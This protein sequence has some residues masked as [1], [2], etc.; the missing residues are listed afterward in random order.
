MQTNKQTG[1]HSGF[2]NPERVTCMYLHSSSAV[3]Q[4]PPVT[5]TQIHTP[6]AGNNILFQLH[7]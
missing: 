5:H 1:L 6:G 7:E 2:H 4:A 3:H